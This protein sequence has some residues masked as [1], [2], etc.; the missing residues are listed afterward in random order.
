MG[1]Y[2]DC[3]LY[4]YVTHDYNFLFGFIGKGPSKSSKVTAAA[5]AYLTSG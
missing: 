4:H 5:A 3:S 2:N 1:E